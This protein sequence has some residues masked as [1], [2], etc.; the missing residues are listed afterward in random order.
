MKKS[1]FIAFILLSGS[2]S[3]CVKEDTK[4]SLY[5]IMKPTTG[6]RKDIGTAD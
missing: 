3:L 6:F 5:A 4:M 1:C 2:L